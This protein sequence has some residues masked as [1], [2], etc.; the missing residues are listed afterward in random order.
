MTD[1]KKAAEELEPGQEPTGEEP[2][3]INPIQGLGE[4]QGGGKSGAED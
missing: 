1:D 4:T 3:T 2:E